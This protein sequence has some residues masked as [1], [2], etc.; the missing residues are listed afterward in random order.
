MR[1]FGSIAAAICA[2][3][4]WLGASGVARALTLEEAL[5]R[6]R[7][8]APDLIASRAELAE[9]RGEVTSAAVP[10]RT[11]PLI[12]AQGGPRYTTDG[13]WIVQLSVGIEQVFELSDARGARIDA[14]R[15][16]VASAEAALAD[17]ARVLTAE[18]ASRYLAALA[19]RDRAALAES[20]LELLDTM[21]EV[22]QR[23]VDA[24]D[25]SI[26]DVR[27]IELAR[28][29]ALSERD[30]ARAELRREIGALRLL[31]GIPAADALDVEGDLAS[32][33]VAWRASTESGERADVVAARAREREAR[34][35]VRV[36]EALAV[37]ELVAGL[38]YQLEEHDHMG[39]LTLGFTLPVFDAGHGA[40]EQAHARLDA[41][42]AELERRESTVA[43]QI[44]T[45][46]EAYDAA[47]DALAA[48]VESARSAGEV[49][50]L[51]ARAWDAGELPL[52]EV[53]LARREVVEARTL[54]VTRA[55][56][57][58]SARMT[59]EAAAGGAR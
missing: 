26:V 55:R 39:L 11:N 36:A 37:P 47:V 32:I 50:V 9:A 27:R 49:E 7:E 15:A 18:V 48:S 51:V 43:V 23:R 52:G 14:A 45:A 54:L 2:V 34:A 21:R 58:A 57:A 40:R 35:R 46:R 6:A 16:R 38:A 56:D 53:L 13:E 59:L 20:G 4:C 29:A 33:A 28:A 31:L 10:L 5:A 42:R 19:A 25:A 22:A 3:V 12:E 44:A 41:A 24:G 30:D 17:V 1:S 8:R